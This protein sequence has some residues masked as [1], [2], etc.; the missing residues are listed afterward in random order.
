MCT[1]ALCVLCTSC[2]FLPHPKFYP[3]PKFTL[4]SSPA[5]LFSLAHASATVARA[6]LFF[7]RMQPRM[8]LPPWRT[9][10]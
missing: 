10:R 6:P 5:W 2:P 9:E 8:F 7:N 4:F 1:E 3:S